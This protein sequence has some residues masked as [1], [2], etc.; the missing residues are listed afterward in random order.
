V[1]TEQP[2][3]PPD[4]VIAEPEFKRKPKATIVIRDKAD[5]RR[6]RRLR[7]LDHQI[8]QLKLSYAK[9][10]Q[11]RTELIER[12]VDAEQFVD[13]NTGRVLGK[14]PAAIEPAAESTEAADAP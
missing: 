3:P 7:E 14:E 10:Q 5:Q 11:D 1:T 2:T 9:A 8:Q 13:A 12:M 4:E 6:E